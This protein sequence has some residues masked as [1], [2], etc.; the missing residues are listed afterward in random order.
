MPA[1]YN[2]T[3]ERPRLYLQC[4]S[5]ERAAWLS[6]HGASVVAALATAESAEVLPAGG[7]GAAGKTCAT[8]VVDDTTTVLMELS[9]ALL[10]K[11]LKR[12]R[13]KQVSQRLLL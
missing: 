4:S 9:G 1:E 7:E 11:E 5:P 10:D 2:L 12:L 13:D 8:A 3:R 6:E